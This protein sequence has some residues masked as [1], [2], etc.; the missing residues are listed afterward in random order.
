MLH[1]L[2][3]TRPTPSRHLRGTAAGGDDGAGCHAAGIGAK[4]PA[5]QRGGVGRDQG[6]AEG[7]GRETGAVANRPQAGRAVVHQ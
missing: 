3:K 1:E 4:G 5:D 7:D 2:I 6:G